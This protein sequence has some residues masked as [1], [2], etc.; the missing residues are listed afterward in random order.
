M[1][2]TLTEMITAM[3][4]ELASTTVWSDTE[5]ARA[6]QKTVNLMSRLVPKRSVLEGIIKGEIS[7][8][9][10]TIATSHGH[11]TYKPI[12]KGSVSITGETEDTDYTVDYQTGTI[13]EIGSLLA[14][15]AYTITYEVDNQQF[16]LSQ[17]S[18]T[19]YIKIESIEYPVG[20][21]PKSM[22]TFDVIAG[23]IVLRGNTVF[24]EDDHIRITYLEKWTAPVAATAGDYPS[25]LD[26]III[27]GA[28][29]QD[30][31][32]RAEQYTQLAFTTI[33][34]ITVPTAYSF[35]KPASVALPTA[36]TAP[37][38]VTPSFTATETALTAIG[39]DIAAAIAYLTTGTAYIITIQDAENVAGIYGEYGNIAMGG[40]P[41]RVNEA[42][43]RL[44]QIEASISNYASQVTAYGSAV[45]AYANNISGQI[46]NFG[47]SVN[48]ENAGIANY[49]IQ[50]QSYVAQVN[51][52]E[53]KIR[54]YLDI[55][56]RYLAS[57]Q[58][59]INEFL[60]AFG[61]K[62]EFIVQRAMSEQRS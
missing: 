21:T 16:D 6:V 5:H 27:I 55:A 8:E 25:H 19:D 61:V 42:I 20:Q 26:D 34:T 48:A 47:A 17:I 60:A 24:T 32:Y 53:A 44:K 7:S 52:Q 41:S 1:T 43:A 45:N 33:S 30:L 62:P 38:L 56:G 46:G 23:F 4:V 3:E 35:A 14:D 59:K 10:L 28:V 29:G 13:T 50:V 22:P 37:T 15:G 49:N 39:T 36:P 11:T 2:M 9:T 12:K 31:I 40:V 57:G 51:M 58:S 18:L 54:N